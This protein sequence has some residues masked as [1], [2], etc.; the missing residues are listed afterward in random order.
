MRGWRKRIRERKE[1]EGNRSEYEE[2][3]ERKNKRGR[4]R[5]GRVIAGGRKGRNRP[6]WKSGR[7]GHPDKNLSDH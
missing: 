6:W 3:E 7:N 1:R 2:D 4:E 5:R